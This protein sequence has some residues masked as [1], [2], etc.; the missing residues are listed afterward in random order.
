MR[1]DVQRE[2]GGALWLLAAEQNC[3][4]ALL[5]DVHTLQT[6]LNEN[7]DY[8][9]LICSPD[10]H[11]DERLALLDKAFR[12]NVHAYVLNFLKIL[13]QRGHFAFLPDCL[14]EYCRKY[15]EANN[16][17]NVTV[18]SAVP[19]SPAQEDALRDKLCAKLGKTIRLHVEVDP[20]VI[21]GIRVQTEKTS[22][23][24]TVRHKIN[25]IRDNLLQSVI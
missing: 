10:V 17:E 24:G 15:D 14:D 19:L 3:S 21:G 20:S 13:A 9:K 11:L 25:T 8:I 2:Y 16:I 18:Y 12:G 5:E 1:S 7:P 4:Q 6:V 22:L 23:D